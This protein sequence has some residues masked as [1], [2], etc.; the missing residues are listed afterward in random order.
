MLSPGRYHEVVPRDLAANLRYR[1][2]LIHH[3]ADDKDAQESLLEACRTDILFW[4]NSFV[5]QYN[6]TKKPGKNVGPFITWAFQE[7]ALLDSPQTTGRKGILWCYENDRSAVVEKSREMGASWLFLIFQDWL[8]L[9]HDHFESLNISRSA[10]AVDSK[11]RKS[12]FPKLRF[13]HEHLPRWMTHHGDTGITQTSMYLHF[14]R[15]LAEITG[16]ASTGRA[17]VGGRAGVVFV[18]EFSKIK[19][20]TQVR[21]GTASTANSRFFNGTHEGV[22]TEFYKITQSPEFVKIRMHWTQHPEKNRGLYKYDHATNR[23]RFYEYRDSDDSIREVESPTYDYPEDYAFDT[24]GAPTG[25]CHPGLRSA[26]YDQ[27]SA[28]IGSNRGVAMELDIDPLGAASQYFDP[29]LIA[30]L[31]Y[32]NCCDPVWVGELEYLKDEARP[33]KLVEERGGKLKLWFRP[34]AYGKPPKGKYAFGA[35]VAQG[36]GVTASC[37]SGANSLGQKIF[38]Y[39][40]AWIEANDF[41]A[42]MVA[43]AR[44]FVDEE[45]QGARLCWE[46]MGPGLSAGLK[47]LE[48]GYSNIF[49]HANELVDSRK[50]FNLKVKA[51]KPGWIPSAKS[52]PI[53]LALY[54][55]MLKTREFVN[56]S[57]DALDQCLLFE[58]NARGGV[59]HGYEQAA[60][61]PSGAK[62]NHADM[63]IADALCAKM[64]KEILEPVEVLKAEEVRPN[65]LAYRHKRYDDERKTVAWVD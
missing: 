20:D 16:E 52:K 43:C 61:D 35:D 51:D 24:S 48:L 25:G 11:S 59:E 32:Q 60:P 13:I 62:E 65:T 44:L 63:V 15:T 28:D 45:G 57:A 33:L 14:P 4:V 55:R 56:R 46:A 53:L 47:I 27:K 23:V 34:D 21:E 18:D 2:R 12:L 7:R 9:F 5:W 30:D 37:L 64:V 39:Q 19:E 17:G 40:D 36:V 1:D 49:Y 58:Y 41:A 50:R 54:R 31:K 22:G 26:W 3:A 10:E 6:P 29:I 8:A 42:L 38:E